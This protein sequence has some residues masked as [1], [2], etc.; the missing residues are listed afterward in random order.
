[1]MVWLLIFT[2]SLFIINLVQ[3]RKFGPLFGETSGSFFAKFNVL[4]SARRLEANRIAQLKH[5]DPAEIYDEEN[6]KLHTPL[7]MEPMEDEEFERMEK[8]ARE[9]A[10][11]DVEKTQRTYLWTRPQPPGLIFLTL[12]Y[13]SWVI[14]GSPLALF[15]D[16]L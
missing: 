13:V 9:Q 3:I 8:Q 4:I 1:M 7:F 10:V 14:F 6:W 2:F 11:T 5:E 16:I 12:G 15:L